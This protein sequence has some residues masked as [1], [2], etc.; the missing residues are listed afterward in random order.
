MQM[1]AKMINSQ[2]HSKFSLWMNGCHFENTFS[3]RSSLTVYMRLLP[4]P[5]LFTFL[6]VI[7]V[8]HNIPPI[9]NTNTIQPI[10]TYSLT[11]LILFQCI[12]FL[13]RGVSV[14]FVSNT[15]LPITNTNI[16]STI[17]NTNTVPPITT[18][19]LPHSFPVYFVPLSW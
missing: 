6:L 19:N 17:T 11:Y 14:I 12:L 4:C 10:P 8:S 7:F 2:G 15:I 3:N 13:Y 9:T 1:N 5:F 18:Y 16:I